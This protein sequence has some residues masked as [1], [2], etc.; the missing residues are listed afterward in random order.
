MD[1]ITNE[2]KNLSYEKDYNKPAPP[3][4][5]RKYIHFFPYIYPKLHGSDES[6]GR[7][8]LVVLI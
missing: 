3:V 2:K 8:F 5:G 6:V 1:N 4:L 7:N